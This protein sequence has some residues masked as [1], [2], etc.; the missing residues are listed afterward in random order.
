M[1]K[2]MERISRRLTK[3]FPIYVFIEVLYFYEMLE[4]NI[5]IITKIVISISVL[6]VVNLLVWID[7][8]EL[9]KNGNVNKKAYEE[10]RR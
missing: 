5:N 1:M 8:N 4:N 3:T 10:F 9:L 6:F 7:Y 2:K